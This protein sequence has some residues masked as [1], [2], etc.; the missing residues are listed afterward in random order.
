MSYFYKMSPRSIIASL[1]RS[2]PIRWDHTPY[3][4]VNRRIREC[5]ERKDTEDTN[6]IGTA[7]YIARERDFETYEQPAAVY[8]QHLSSLK[9]LDRPELGCLVA[10][11]TTL[12]LKDLGTD[13][14]IAF[15]GSLSMEHLDRIYENK[16]DFLYTLHI[17][18]VTSLS[19]IQITHRKGNERPVI[20]NQRKSDVDR[21]VN[22]IV[23]LV[24]RRCVQPDVVYYLP[25]AL[26]EAH[27]AT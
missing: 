1:F 2:E 7:L 13:E 26:E 8:L 25:K 21:T 5:A 11:H 27:R 10:W 24:V 15:E 3:P 17:G 18:I 14:W 19:P 4:E 23:D 12:N 20:V 22:G 16:W 9:R 6:C